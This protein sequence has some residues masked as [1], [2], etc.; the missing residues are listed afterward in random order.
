MAGNRRNLDERLDQIYTLLREALTPQEEG[1]ESNRAWYTPQMPPIDPG[2]KLSATDLLSWWFRP[3]TASQ[4]PWDTYFAESTVAHESPRMA[5]P[6]PAAS[7]ADPI[8]RA[9]IRA[10]L[11]VEESELASDDADRATETFYEFLHAIGRRDVDVAMQYIADDF[12]TFEDDREV[13]R[14]DLRSRME[15]LLDAMHGYDI[16]VSLTTVPEPLQHPYGV[17]MSVEIQLDGVHPQ[18]KAKRNVLDKR[19]V[20][21][22][23]QADDCWKITSL[24]R[25]R[26]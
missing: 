10:L 14:D 3:P 2:S 22:Q 8:S 17:V 12:H 9:A 13:D 16:D 20:L 15:G 26:D 7:P 5:A 23:R 6:P 19:L 11:P 1:Q 25:A 21:L 4:N 24:G 18:T